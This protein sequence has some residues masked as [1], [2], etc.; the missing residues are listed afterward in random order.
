M[1]GAADE[2]IKTERDVAL[3]TITQFGS[4]HEKFDWHLTFR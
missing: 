1:D 2:L 4:S 3:F